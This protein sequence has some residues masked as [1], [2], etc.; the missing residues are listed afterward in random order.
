MCIVAHNVTLLLGVQH[1]NSISLHIMRKTIKL[2]EENREEKFF[3]I[4]FSNYFLDIMPKALATKEN[5]DKSVKNSYTWKSTV[6]STLIDM[7]FQFGKVKNVLGMDDGDICKVM[8]IVK[9]QWIVK[10]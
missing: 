7:D 8:W 4:G 5:I 6:K 1:S 2:L 10:Q 3:D 9:W